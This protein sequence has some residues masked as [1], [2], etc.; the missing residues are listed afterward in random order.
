M[1][2]AALAAFL[3]VTAA[4]EQP[5]SESRTAIPSQSPAATTAPEKEISPAGL[6]LLERMSKM[7]NEARAQALAD[8]PTA[9][10]ERIEKGLEGLDALT[11]QQ[12]ENW[13]RRYRKFYQLTEQQK[14]EV[15]AILTALKALPQPRRKAVQLEIDTYRHMPKWARE[16]RMRSA[17]FKNKFNPEERQI[18][19]RWAVMLAEPSAI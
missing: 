15:R 6:D 3:I 10:R 19:H 8:V 11:P 16:S 4:A 2:T 12:R 13:F 1:I 14:A 17:D 7:S 9:R 18:V 5:K